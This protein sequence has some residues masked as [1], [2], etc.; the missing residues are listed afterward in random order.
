MKSN[1]KIAL[2]EA[3]GWMEGAH[4]KDANEAET[5]RRVERI[6]ERVCGYDGLRHLS[7]EDSIR[8]PGEVE[9]ADYTV[10]A[11]GDKISFVVEVKRCS[12]KLTKKHFNQVTAYA[13]N[14]G[15][16]WVLVTNG[17]QWQ[18]HH[19][20]SSPPS[21]LNL[22]EEWDILHDSP[23]RCARCFALIALVSVRKGGLDKL[24]K[25]RRA[26]TP[27]QVAAAL[28]SPATI[29]CIRNVLGRSTGH[30]PRPEDIVSA[31]RKTLNEAA[32]DIVDG[33]E[34][35]LPA[36]TQKRPARVPVDQTAA[37]TEGDQQAAAAEVAQ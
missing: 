4:Q 1:S 17:R 12:A 29:K 7:R 8:G 24:W 36:A 25:E 15:C 18:L 32:Q 19:W 5:R 30:R 16:E 21:A 26:L 9:F 34:I 27:A 33:L 22:V 2:R 37:S 14:L 23:D 13:T 35:H 3:R 31:V 11:R 28:V 10:R 6:L 20:D